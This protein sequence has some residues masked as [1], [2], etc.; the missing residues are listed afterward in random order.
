MDLFT[1]GVESSLD[2]GPLD[3]AAVLAGEPFDRGESR[4]ANGLVR[5]AREGVLCPVHRDFNE[6][7]SLEAVIRGSGVLTRYVDRRSRFGQIQH[8]CSRGSAHVRGQGQAHPI[9]LHSSTFFLPVLA[10]SPALWKEGRYVPFPS[11]SSKMRPDAGPLL[12]GLGVTPDEVWRRAGNSVS[13][14]SSQASEG[15][16]LFGPAAKRVVQFAAAEARGS[17]AGV[18]QCEHFLLGLLKDPDAVA[19]RVLE[20]KGLSYESAKKQLTSQA[21]LQ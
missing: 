20:S 1:L 15:Q 5:I 12:E 16:S 13:T 18:V 11:R 9:S 2:V 7:N 3:S 14:G 6:L 10:N 21:S 4:G 17:G 19:A 8:Q